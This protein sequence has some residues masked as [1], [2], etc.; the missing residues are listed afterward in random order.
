MP[1]KNYHGIK[2]LTD[3]L[4]FTFGFLISIS[5]LFHFISTRK[6]ISD[7]SKKLEESDLKLYNDS[8]AKYLYDEVKILCWVFTHPENHKTKAVTVKNTWGKRCNKLL[9][10]STEEDPEIGTVALPVE[11]GRD[12]L[13]SKTQ[14]AINYVSLRL[15]SLFLFI[16]NAK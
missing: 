12:H 13:W 15:L 14:K 3:A 9:L 4:F 6:M 2:K 8:L 7:S 11:N 16:S 1:S 10:M 5:I